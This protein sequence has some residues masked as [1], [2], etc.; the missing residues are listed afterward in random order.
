M[1]Q[2][3]TK[4]VSLRD[5]IRQDYTYSC[6]YC[7]VSES[8]VGST[9]TVDH[10]HPTIH[11][12]TNDIN[13]LVY[14]CH[15]CNE[16]KGSYWHQV[17]VPH[18]RLL[19]PLIDNLSHHIQEQLNGQLVGI[20]PEGTFYVQRLRLNRP[21]LIEHRLRKSA[22]EKLSSE[23]ESLRQYIHELQQELSKLNMNLQE[24]LTEIDR[25]TT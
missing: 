15:R 21:Q 19:H 7:G 3:N 13:N 11:G 24:I 23:V 5:R 1:R 25:E 22:D 8:D 12:G 14:C 16:H 2:N 4:S 17:N 9:L 10:H 6:G 20:T 18:I